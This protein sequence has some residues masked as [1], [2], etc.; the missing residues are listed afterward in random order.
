MAAAD[1][2]PAQP[3]VLGPTI[4]HLIGSEPRHVTDEHPTDVQP[5]RS[6]EGGTWIGGE[7]PRPQP[8]R[9][10]G[11]PAAIRTGYDLLKSDFLLAEQ[12]GRLPA[13]ADFAAPAGASAAQRKWNRLGRSLDSPGLRAE[14][15]FALRL[16]KVT[17]R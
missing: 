4:R 9:R 2:L 14:L 5:L 17:A 3:G 8:E 1:P 15:W 6:R 7:H 10:H 13:D 12:S 16:V 11:S